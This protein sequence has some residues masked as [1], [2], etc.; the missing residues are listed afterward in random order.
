MKCRN[1]K[2]K[3]KQSCATRGKSAPPVEAGK[4]EGR[5]PAQGDLFGGPA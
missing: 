1:Y 2:G 3:G 5:K 4:A